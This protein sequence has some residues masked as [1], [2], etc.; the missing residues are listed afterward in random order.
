M[1]CPFP[2]NTPTHGYI[3][4]PSSNLYALALTIKHKN[5]G[6]TLRFGTKKPKKWEDSGET[7]G[8]PKKN[9][10][11]HTLHTCPHPPLSSPHVDTSNTTNTPLLLSH[12]AFIRPLPSFTHQQGRQ[13]TK[14]KGSECFS[15]KK[16]KIDREFLI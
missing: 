12:H 13:R 5:G 8:T 2:L 16:N 10:S 3:F 7:N 4:D 11:H 9:I 14:K 1:N 6:R 15:R